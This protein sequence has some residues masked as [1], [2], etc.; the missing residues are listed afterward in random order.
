MI[1]TDLPNFFSERQ[2]QFA[3]WYLRD[4]EQVVKHL[5]NS[6]SD[7]RVHMKEAEQEAAHMVERIRERKYEHSN[8]EIM[9]HEYS[10]DSEE[11][12]V[13]MCLA[14]ALLRIPDNLTA[15]RLIQGK[16]SAANWEHHLGEGKSLFLNASTWGLM[17]TGKLLRPGVQGVRS[18]IDVMENLVGRLGEPVV[19][20]V[21]RQMMKLLGK[22]FVMGTDIDGALVNSALEAN[23]PYRYSFDMLGEAAITAEDA[24]KY[25]NAYVKAIEQIGK[26]NSEMSVVVSSSI[27]IKL[28]ALHPRYELHQY[29]RVIEEMAAK[30]QELALLAKGFNIGLTVDAEEADRLELSLAV[31]SKVYCSSAFSGW[32][33][34]GLAVQAYQKRALL[35]IEFLA[36]LSQRH[37]RRIPVRLVK[38]AYWDTEIKHAQEQGL[39]SYPVFTRKEAT[40][41]SYLVCA[42]KLIEN[43]RLLYPQFATHNAFT[44]ACVMKMVSFDVE[45]EFQRLHG[46]GGE[47]YEEAMM[48]YHVP[49]RTY[50]PVGRHEDLLPYLVRR[51]LENGANTS[52]VNR[53]EDHKIPIDQIVANPLE[54]LE[55]YESTANPRIVLPRELF[56]SERVNSSSKNLYSGVTLNDL[57]QAFLDME[58]HKKRR[59]R[60]IVS[61]KAVKSD[62]VQKVISP[63]DGKVLGESCLASRSQVSD[64]V[65]A[66][67]E[68][69]DEW[70]HTSAEQRALLLEKMAEL[71]E[72]HCD[73]LMYLCVYEAGRSVSD[74]LSEIREAVDFCRYYA[75][76]GRKDFSHA[77]LLPGPTGESNQLSLLGRG[78]FVCISPWNFPVAIF[79]G[80]IAAALM[81][82]NVV[83]AKPASKTTL[84]ASRC[85]ELFHQ[86]GIPDDVLH[87]LAVNGNELEQWLLGDERISGVAFTGSTSVAQSIHRKLAEREGPLAI[88]VGETGG[89]NVMIADSSALPEQLVKDCI[90]SAFNSAGQR[91]SALR[92]LFVQQDISDRVIELMIGAMKELVV[93]DPAFV[94]TDVGPVIDEAAQTTINAHIDEMKHKDRLLYQVEVPRELSGSFVG[95]ALI[96]LDRLDELKGEVFGPVLHIVRYEANQLEN[97][98]DVINSTGYGLTF[99]I[100]SRVD[101]TIAYLSEKVRAGNVYVNRNMI[102]AVVGVQPFGGMGLSGTG[103]KAGGPHYLHRFATERTV[104][105][106]T[107]AVGGNAQ[108]LAE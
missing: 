32:E 47:L 30:L 89:Q 108:L 57:R 3:D 82:G 64:A 17:L 98:V 40:D 101:Q 104:T 77:L 27:S 20:T 10:L 80:Q 55:K 59:A 37:Q 66:S 31:F 33:G 42:K 100:H 39:S 50:A 38:G 16:I 58:K 91:C 22:Q 62:L 14:E 88:F 84:L 35:V 65:Q 86:A 69:F 94:M 78:V 85:I 21:L 81:A 13:L 96:E 61:G 63:I 25:F 19:R 90:F 11:G 9:M 83:I 79:V 1:F 75:A 18:F 97:V 67:C 36:S 102:G 68:A 60:S 71:L 87:L 49:C 56:G 70:Q 93:G 53:I 28:S 72:Q 8:I 74:S 106:N 5:I 107:A 105:I 12:V 26:A 24:T 41:V 73:E 99:G 23:K 95:P 34:L 2:S 103:P 51:L 7:L 52:F 92:V 6:L 46:M 44:V 45:F 76:M 43:H 4:E 54:T 29:P 48:H 15:D